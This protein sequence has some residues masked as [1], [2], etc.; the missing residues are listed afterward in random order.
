[1]KRQQ[2]GEPVPMDT[3]HGEAAGHIIRRRCYL[4]PELLQ[5][6]QMPRGTF[7]LL[8]RQGKLGAIVE[9]LQPRVGRV[10]RFRADLVDR[11]LD[12]K[13]GQSRAFGRRV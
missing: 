6:L 8:K 10:M 4:L 7:F 1:M 9:E 2:A 5:I 13:T 12:G 3:Q 11:Y